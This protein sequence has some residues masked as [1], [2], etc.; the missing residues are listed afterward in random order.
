MRWEVDE[1]LKENEGL[2]LAE[3]ELASEEQPF[4]LPS[5]A[6]QEVSHDPRYHNANLA[7]HPY[8]RWGNKPVQ[9]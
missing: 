8:L 1:F 9:G 5:W 3:I 7:K 2:I 6:G 4:D